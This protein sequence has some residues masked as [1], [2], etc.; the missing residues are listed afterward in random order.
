MSSPSPCCLITEVPAGLEGNNCR[1]ELDVMLCCR[2][3][4]RYGRHI[5]EETVD[6]GV[7]PARGGAIMISGEVG[8]TYDR[9]H[10]RDPEH[11]GRDG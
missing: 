3:R 9:G 7:G 5:R 8:L 10:S 4:F 6:P 2:L 11:P 1:L